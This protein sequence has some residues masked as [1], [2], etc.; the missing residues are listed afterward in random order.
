LV[1][2]ELEYIK[3]EYGDERKT[4]LSNDLSV[5]NLDKAMRDLKKNEDFVKENVL[6]WK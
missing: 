3:S 5:Y 6:V 4:E 1:V 2:D